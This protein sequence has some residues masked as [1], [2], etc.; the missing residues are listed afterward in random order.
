MVSAG[1]VIAEHVS[2]IGRFW[3][4]RRTR[5]PILVVWVASFGGALHAA[6]TT[7]FYLEVGA[8]EADIGFI[9]FIMSLG[10]L[11]FSP[12]CG[13]SLDVLGPFAP[14]SVT[15][16]ACALG[17]FFRGAA[18]SPKGLYLGAAFL[19]L[20][21]NMWTCVLAHLSNCFDRRQRSSV[22]SAFAVQETALR[23]LGKGLFPAGDYFLS[24]NLGISETLPKFRI[25]MG[26]CTLFCMFG[27]AILAAER[28]SLTCTAPRGKAGAPGAAHAT[29]LD[30]PFEVMAGAHGH[31][32]CAPEEAAASHSRS[33][34]AH[35]VM[36][37]ALLIQ[38]FSTTVLAVLW[39]LFLRDRFSFSAAEYGAAA[40][41][42]SL[43]ATGSTASFP[44]FER[45]FGPF[46]TA[47]ACAAAAATSMALG[48]VVLPG[49][50]P[51]PSVA[52]GML[53]LDGTSTAATEAAVV[54]REGMALHIALAVALHGT[55]LTLEPSLKSIFSL[56]VPPAAQGRSIGLMATIG[57]I[58][59][60][61]GN[62]AGTWLYTTSKGW[63][64]SPFAA[65]RLPFAAVAL[66]LAV[67]AAAVGNLE[68]PRRANPEACLER[69]EKVA[70]S[71][72][73]PPPGAPP[74]TAVRPKAFAEPD[75]GP[76]NE[77]GD[78]DVDDSSGV[79]CLQRETSYDL[80]LD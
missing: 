22:L 47:S 7:Y 20:G 79:C 48:F 45:K 3:N 33:W 61:G 24:H 65:G 9:G 71:T 41:T 27:T 13:W 49:G 39:P 51:S 32:G 10:A 15:A 56:S 2:M 28:V 53:P 67:A 1:S 12:L 38:S 34:R 21:V 73:A 4:D 54:A 23:L 52:T 46:F 76:S 68:E 77:A 64:G 19:G 58:G 43:V 62:L 50:G 6:V 75:G 40:F 74:A 70:A 25:H 59:G 44:E 60:M 35:A 63:V 55:L 57:G 5:T 18:T 36:V 72:A 80:K 11:C 26:I 29:T 31:G 42:A 78:N 69:G 8:S 14:I 66:L 30:P 16:S 17:C 37:G